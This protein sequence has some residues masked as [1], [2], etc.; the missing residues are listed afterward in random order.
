MSYSNQSN[1]RD[2]LETASNGLFVGGGLIT[3]TGIFLGDRRAT[4]AGVFLL[5]LAF[6]GYIIG[7]SRN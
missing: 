7:R 3:L 1:R 4:N 2:D 5:I 6:I